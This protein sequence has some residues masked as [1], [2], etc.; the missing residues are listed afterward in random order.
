MDG[1]GGRAQN[2]PWVPSGVLYRGPASLMS[3]FDASTVRALK[4]GIRV[5]GGSQM[6]MTGG[7]G[8]L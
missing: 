3:F 2:Q 7:F 6:M 8:G 1:G 5:A 4:P